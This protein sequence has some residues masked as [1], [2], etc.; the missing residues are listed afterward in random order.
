M[1]GDTVVEVSAL[2]VNGAIPEA[3]VLRVN[4]TRVNVNS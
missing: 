1:S 2:A 3:A 4:V